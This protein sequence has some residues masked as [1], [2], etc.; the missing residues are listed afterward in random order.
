MLFQVPY[1][2]APES[3]GRRKIIYRWTTLFPTSLFEELFTS[4]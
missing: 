3:F 2:S 4:R 1:S